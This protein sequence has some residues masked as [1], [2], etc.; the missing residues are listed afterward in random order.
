MRVGC[1]AVKERAQRAVNVKRTLS[2]AALYYIKVRVKRPSLPAGLETIT[3][4]TK[5]VPYASPVKPPECLDIPA[6]PLAL[7]VP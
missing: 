5:G 6:I 7:G 1:T 4:G 3:K 2:T